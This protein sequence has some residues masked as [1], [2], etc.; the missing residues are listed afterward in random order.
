[1]LIDFHTH[2][3]PAKLAQKALESLSKT[4]KS[5]YY[6]DGTVTGTTRCLNEWGVTAAVVMNIAT[7]PSQQTTV[8]NWAAS[9]QNKNI[10]CFGSVHPDAPD[11]VQEVARLKVLGLYGVKFHPDYQSFFVDEERMYP[12]YDAISSL[13][14]PVLFHA[15]ADPLSPNLV[16]AEPKALAKIAELFPKMKIIAAHMGGM[17]RCDEVEEYLIGRNMFIDTAM[18]SY[19]C[20]PEQFARIIRK[21]GTD[22]IVFGSDCPWSR[23]NE[24]LRYLEKA[25]LNGSDMD[26]IMYQNALRILNK[27]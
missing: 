11:A 3:F 7:K 10:Y 19:F 24:G 26:K 4:C 6:T 21:H 2:M 14:L 9:I 16:H 22:K 20:P 18:A 15:G 17:G 27:S 5:P 25:K 23:A 13:G 1:M 8:N 12:I